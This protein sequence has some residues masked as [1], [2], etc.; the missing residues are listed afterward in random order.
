MTGE[1][2]C[3]LVRQKPRKKLDN[4]DYPMGWISRHSSFSTNKLQLHQQLYPSYTIQVDC[5]ECM[6]YDNF[7]FLSLVFTVNTFE[8]MSTCTASTAYLSTVYLSTCMQFTG[9]LLMLQ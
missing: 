6:S 1:K 9:N 8:K 7:T 4:N 3:P 2:S 5:T